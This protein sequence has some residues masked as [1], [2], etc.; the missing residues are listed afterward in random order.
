MG[1]THVRL[2]AASEDVLAGAIRTAWRLRLG[3]NA[4]TRAK[5]RS[6]ATS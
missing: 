2:A 3:K 4:K 6:S 1:H 5:S